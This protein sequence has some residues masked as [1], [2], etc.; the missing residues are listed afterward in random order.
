MIYQSVYQLIGHTPLLQ[1]DIDVP[2]GSRI[3]AKIET[4]NPGGSVKDRLGLELV[5]EGIRDKKII[6]GKTTIIEPTAGN[7]GIGI[8]LAAQKYHLPVTFVVPDKFSVEKQTIMRA[9]G[10][11]IVNTPAADGM[12]GA[13]RKAE[14][15]AKKTPNSYVPMQFTNPANPLTYERTLGPEIVAD[16][17]GEP[18]TA[19][20]AGA[21]TGGTFAGTAHALLAAY[22][23]LKTVV[24]EP[25]GSILNGGPAHPHRT[26]GIGV[27]MIPP[28]FKDLHISEVQT[29][30]DD[31]AF[32]QVRRA[33]SELGLLIGS[34]SGAAL[35]ASLNVA[36]EL[37]ANSTIVTIFPDGS[38]RYLSDGI[39]D[40]DDN[41]GA[42]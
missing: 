12:K 14:E 1:L 38:D 10:A 6:P 41:Q 4:K 17:A 20:V 26:E 27:E 11:K 42:D 28:F 34:S 23:D 2:N 16:L 15:L 36:K 32:R 19:F 30:P 24:V 3:L 29:I 35:Q 39:Y 5:E 33:A 7:T 13:S 18:L 8:A 37:P 9:L 40:D 25:D 21:G 31:D 22:P